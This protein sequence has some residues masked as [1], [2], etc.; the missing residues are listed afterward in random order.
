M[1]AGSSSSSQT[2]SLSATPWAGFL[3]HGSPDSSGIWHTSLSSL[4]IF[5]TFLELTKPLSHPP[6]LSCLAPADVRPFLDTEVL[7]ATQAACSTTAALATDPHFQVVK[8][9]LASSHVLLCSTS[10]GMNRPLF[11]REFRRQAFDA[12]HAL[13]H[14]GVRGSHRLLATRFLWPGMNKDVGAW[15]SSCLDCQRTKVARHMRPPVQ[16]IDMPSQRF[17]H[18]HIDLVGPLP[19]VR[20]YTHMFTMVDRS[21]RWPT[22]YPIQDTTTTACINTLVEWISCFGVPAT[23]TSD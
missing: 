6:Q 18:V 9:L 19:S 1:K 2:T 12:L 16:R 23:V 22:A 15:A 21:T 5:E 14:P 10:T 7:S 17:S 4:K 13:S 11:L 20:G 8:R 3:L